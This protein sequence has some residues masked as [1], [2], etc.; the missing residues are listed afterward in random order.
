M[1]R[2]ALP[3][4]SPLFL[5][6]S[7]PLSLS[8]VLTVSLIL[9]NSP[10]LSLCLMSGNYFPTHTQTKRGGIVNW[11]THYEKQNGGFSKK[12]KTELPYDPTTPLLGIYLKK[13][14]NT[15]L[16]RNMQSNIHNSIIYNSQDMEAT[17]MPINK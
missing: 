15:N 12:L 14:E 5:T 2:S 1:K 9:V 3:S 8:T 7:S 6:V 4:A 11:C 17:Q 10:L 16:K 13:N